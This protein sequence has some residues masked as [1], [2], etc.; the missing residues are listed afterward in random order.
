MAGARKY[1]YPPTF[2]YHEPWWGNY[3]YINDHYAR[4]SMTLSAGKQINSIL[5]IEPTTSAWLYDSYTARNPQCNTIGQSFQDFISILEKSQVE[6]DLGSEQIIKDLGSVKGRKLVVG[7][8]SYKTVVLPPLTE[9]IDLSTFK[10]LQKFV[11]RGGRLIVFSTPSL[12]DGNAD[13]SLKSFFE[14]YADR[15]SHEENLTADLITKYFKDQETN[16]TGVSGGSLYHHRRVLADGQ[17]LF[18]VNSSL[19]ENVI[20]SVSTDGADAIEMNTLTGEIYGYPNKS[21]GNSVSITF[22][23]PPA[24]SLLLYIPKNRKTDYDMPEV[25]EEFTRVPGASSMK[26]RRDYDNAIAIPFCDLLLDGKLSRDL[27][28]YTAADMVYKHYGFK[29][30]NPWNHA[31]QFK[32]NITGRDKFDANSGFTAEYHFNIKGKFDYSSFRAVIERPYLWKVYI[33]GTGIEPEENE[34]WLD[35]EFAVFDISSYLIQ[36]NNTI[37]LKT[38]P[39]KVYAEIEPVYITGDFSVSPASKGWLIEAPS[40]SLR[41]GSWK[42]QGM[43]F[44]SWTVTYSRDFN[45]EQQNS[46][47][48]VQLNDWKGTIA[49]VSVNGKWAGVIAF[50]PYNLNVTK[51]IQPGTNTIDVKVTGSLKNLMG[52]HFNDPAPGMTGPGHWRN[53]KNYPDGRDYQLLDYGLMEDFELLKIKTYL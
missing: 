5:I 18:L 16:F 43:P 19:D 40:G 52:P 36:G 32:T 49:E 37:T 44:Y 20:G 48:R 34:W 38:A 7:Q 53:V 41:S 4:L 50:P 10:L 24:G 35:R 25:P 39:V 12:V 21:E 14:K 23:L 45:V 11:A 2:S 47:Y 29:D 26:I 30:G 51:L 9:N 1:D 6:Y 15:I 28:N 33:N 42:D 8:C 46:I 27:H 13:E 3:K 17:I 22:N 31:V